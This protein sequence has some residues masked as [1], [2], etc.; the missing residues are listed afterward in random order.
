[1]RYQEFTVFFVIGSC[2]V[3]DLTATVTLVMFYIIKVL[4]NSDDP[5]Q[6]AP[7][8]TGFSLFA[9]AFSFGH[10]QTIQKAK[11][12]IHPLSRKDDVDC[13]LPN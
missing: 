12:F 9:Y 11:C 5:S 6:T 3:N 8:W 10:L 2:T 7:K 13:F 1:M 4:L